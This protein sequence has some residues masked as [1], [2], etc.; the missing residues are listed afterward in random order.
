MNTLWRNEEYSDGVRNAVKVITFEMYEL[1]N[2][3]IPDTVYSRYIQPNEA[4]LVSNFS[5]PINQIKVLIEDED[6]DTSL[7]DQYTME[8]KPEFE[9]LAKD[10]ISI[11]QAVTGYSI[12]YVLWLATKE[13]VKK[14]YKGDCFNMSE[15]ETSPIILSDLGNEGFLFGYEK[16]P[17]EL[18]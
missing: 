8:T 7:D 17:K 2:I 9:A 3:D 4:S 16:N 5:T 13:S 18:N 12:K 1:G 15:Y 6:R 14:Y 10:I 11:V